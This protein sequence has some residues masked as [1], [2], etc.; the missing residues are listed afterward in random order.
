[1]PWHCDLGDVFPDPYA[2]IGVRRII[3][4]ASCEATGLGVVDDILA[5]LRRRTWS[6]R[7]RE[8]RKHERLGFDEC[9]AYSCMLANACYEALGSHLDNKVDHHFDL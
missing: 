6:M 7:N 9:F 3:C 8:I 1:M 4:G 2:R 5:F